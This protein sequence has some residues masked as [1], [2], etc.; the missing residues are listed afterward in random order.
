MGDYSIR[1]RRGFNRIGWF[2][3]LFSGFLAVVTIGVA[4]YGQ[5]AGA[6]DNGLYALSVVFAVSGIG[7]FFIFRGVAWALSGFVDGQ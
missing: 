4:T 6:N 3:L 7:L 2:C 5:F 1:V